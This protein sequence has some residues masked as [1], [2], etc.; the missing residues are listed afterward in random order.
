M[1]KRLLTFTLIIAIASAA[2]ANQGFVIV[3][4]PEIE[5]Q[6]LSK[7]AW[8]AI[9]MKKN[10]TWPDGTPIVPIDQEETS[11]VRIRFT[12]VVHRKRVS[13]V[14]TYWHQQIFSGREMPPPEKA[15][16]AAVVA[17]VRAT[18]GAVGYV[19]SQAPTPGLTRIELP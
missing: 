8:S 3:A 14:R 4:H 6:T 19:S 18:P 9:F 10:R 5:S 7:Q 15:S 2:W 1:M 16:D 12:T 17:F 13:A 11:I